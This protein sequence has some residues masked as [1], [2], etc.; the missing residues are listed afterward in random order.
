MIV[1]VA[2]LSG[3]N[4]IRN[5]G[6]SAIPYTF[7]SNARRPSLWARVSLLFFFICCLSGVYVVFFCCCFRVAGKRKALRVGQLCPIRRVSRI[8]FYV[9]SCFLCVY[10]GALR[11]PPILTNSV[12]FINKCLLFIFFKKPLEYFFSLVLLYRHQR[13]DVFI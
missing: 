3:L 5:C 4:G 11:H 12:E 6:I 13:K 1:F 8:F 10:G 9:Y 7:I 2:P